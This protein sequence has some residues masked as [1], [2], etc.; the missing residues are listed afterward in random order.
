MQQ[1]RPKHQIISG[2]PDRYSG[3][4]GESL[5]RIHQ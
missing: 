2:A 5:A 3:A 1:R 4:G